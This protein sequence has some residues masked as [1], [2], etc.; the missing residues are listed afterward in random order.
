VYDNDILL[1]DLF[2]AS[3]LVSVSDINLNIFSGL[4]SEGKNETVDCASDFFA[5]LNKIKINKNENKI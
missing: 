4:K 3:T 5:N 2:N 1:P